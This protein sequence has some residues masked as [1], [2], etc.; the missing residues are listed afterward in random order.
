[1]YKSI[2]DHLNGDGLFSKLKRKICDPVGGVLGLF[3][4]IIMYFSQ[5][6]IYEN[7]GKWIKSA[8][9]G[10]DKFWLQLLQAYAVVTIPAIAGGIY[11]VPS[12]D[13]L[14]DAPLF[15]AVK[16]GGNR[17]YEQKQIKKIWYLCNGICDVLTFCDRMQCKERG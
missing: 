8:L 4:L 10:R 5:G 3:F 7:R 16:S 12:R 2:K 13:T 14:P 11:S 1:M 15:L 17:K 9:T 6:R